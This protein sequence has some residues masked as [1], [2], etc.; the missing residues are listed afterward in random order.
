M[1]LLVIVLSF[2]TVAYG[3]LLPEYLT[4]NCPQP[5][6]D[7]R[8]AQRKDTAREVQATMKI[9]IRKL[10]LLFRVKKVKPIPFSWQNVPKFNTEVS[11]PQAWL[12]F[13]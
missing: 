7:Q 10:S 3:F 5:D 12:K 9:L 2:C 6:P 1:K 11:T 13:M 4:L 8:E